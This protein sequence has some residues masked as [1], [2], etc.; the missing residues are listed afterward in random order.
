VLS[1]VIVDDNAAFL[2]A[3]SLLLER[4][5]LTVAGVASNAAEA[6]RQV[7]ALR[8]EVILVDITL[9]AE[10]GLDLARRLA[11]HGSGATVILISTHADTDFADLIAETRAAGFVPKAEL[12][13][14]AVE[15]LAGASP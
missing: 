8:P 11:G 2:E 5:G 14:A 6:L 4:Q 7:E 13:A 1:C 9:G 15:R 3:A 12:S 10:S